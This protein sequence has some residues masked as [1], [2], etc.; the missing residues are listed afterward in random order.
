MT[1]TLRAGVIGAGVFGGYHAA[2]YAELPDVRLAAILD[3]HPERE[4]ALVAKYGGKACESLQDL[5][6]QVDVV[7]IAA[8]AIHHGRLA[9]A[10]LAAG[11]SV[12]VEKPIAVSLEDADA[13]V[14]AADRRGLVAACGFL[15]RAAFLAMGLFE[16]PR[17]PLRMECARLGPASPRNL[18]VSVVI[19]LMIHDL[20]LALA[21]AVA[22]PLAVEAEGACIANSLI[23]EAR[24][25]VSFDDG[26]TALCRASR[27][28]AERERTLTLVY[29]RGEVRLDLLTHAFEN[30]TPY[31]L[32]LGF[33]D[34]P[35]SKDRLGA[36]LAAFLAAVRGD[37]VPLAD[38]RDGARALDLALAVE[39]A[40]GG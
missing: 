6:N 15:E 24:A 13:I 30:T 37:G 36:S 19:D 34:D 14:A 39:Q 31:A 10:A 12:Y 35:R 38:A 17:A 40:V 23:D 1:S 27:V 3:P 5:L 9:L 28:A 29:P 16:V 25:E 2:K 8:P 33:E 4:A 20:D 26:F 11:K 7:S 22:E 18:D 21:L 32:N